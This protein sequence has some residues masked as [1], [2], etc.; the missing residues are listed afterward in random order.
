MQHRNAG[1]EKVQDIQMT[2]HMKKFTIYR[3]RTVLLTVLMTITS[4]AVAQC[5][6][7]KTFENLLAD[8]WEHLDTVSVD[9]NSKRHQ[10]WVGGN[11]CSLS[12]VTWL[13]IIC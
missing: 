3:M 10:F 8:R 7:C 1:H 12:T 9:K 11:D 13:P 4:Y 5:G 2:T 6:Y